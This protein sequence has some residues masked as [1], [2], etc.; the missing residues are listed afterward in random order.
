[1]S[2][3]CR[4]C[5]RREVAIV[6]QLL[7]DPYDRLDRLPCRSAS[8]RQHLRIAASPRIQSPPFL[9]Y[10]KDHL[11]VSGWISST[12]P[13]RLS[14]AV[15]SCFWKQVALLRKVF[16]RR[17]GLT[18]RDWGRVLP[19]GRASFGFIPRRIH[20]SRSSAAVRTSGIAWIGSTTPFARGGQQALKL[21]GSSDWM[22]R[23]PK[24]L[25]HYLGLE[26]LGN[27]PRVCLDSS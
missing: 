20:T 24:G 5:S 4:S 8:G 15:R 13:L 17:S 3:D 22:I 27:L 10:A 11:I 25:L 9:A 19:F 21:A 7:T 26:L 12:T 1:M 14:S 18:K 2:L 23:T 16:S 6:L